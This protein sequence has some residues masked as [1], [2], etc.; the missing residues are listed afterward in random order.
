MYTFLPL[1]TFFFSRHSCFP[2]NGHPPSLLLMVTY[3]HIMLSVCGTQVHPIQAHFDGAKLVVRF[4]PRQDISRAADMT[5]EKM[6]PLI[7]CVSGLAVG[8]TTTTTFPVKLVA[9]LSPAKC[10]P[11]VVENET[12]QAAA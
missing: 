2:N 12:V 7:R 5:A 3:E 8:D 10:R 4:S 6:V 9:P 1:H 11:V